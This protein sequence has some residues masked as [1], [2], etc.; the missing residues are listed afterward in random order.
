MVTNLGRMH[1]HCAHEIERLRKQFGFA[2]DN[3]SIY[4]NMERPEYFK[5][6]D[7]IIDIELKNISKKTLDIIKRYEEEHLRKRNSQE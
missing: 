1:T 3:S 5:E 6:I 4:I 7:K 2:P